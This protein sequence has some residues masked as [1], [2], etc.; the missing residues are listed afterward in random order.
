MQPPKADGIFKCPTYVVPPPPN[1]YL[2]FGYGFNRY[3]TFVPSYVGNALGGDCFLKVNH[4]KPTNYIIGDTEAW[5]GN[6]SIYMWAGAFTGP[7]YC[8]VATNNMFVVPGSK[9]VSEATVAEPRPTTGPAGDEVSVVV[10]LVNNA[11]RERVAVARNADYFG[12]LGLMVPRL[13]AR[14]ALSPSPR[15]LPP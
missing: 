14:Q 13:P 12:V 5:A 4:L 9:A 8:D 15:P 1:D 11:D 10:V 7:P 6:G 3:L 2:A